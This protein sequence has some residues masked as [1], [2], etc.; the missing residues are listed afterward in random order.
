MSR[1]V[2][3]HRLAAASAALALVLAVGACDQKKTAESEAPAPA[4]TAESAPEPAAAETPAPAEESSAPEAAA[5]ESA[6]PEPAAAEAPAPSETPV[7]EAGHASAEST[8]QA[9][10][11]AT[12]AATV[13]INADDIVLGSPTAPVT[14]IEYASV[15]CSHCAAFHAQTYPQLKAAYIDTGK[16]R[17]VFREFPTSPP[18]LAGAGF[19]LARCAGGS[20]RYMG[21]IG[22]LMAHQKDW[23]FNADPQARFAAFSSIAGQAGIGQE[24]LQTC[25][26]D[27][28]ELDHI[29]A[30]QREGAT[31]FD[32][33]STPTFII[34]GQK[35]PGARSFEAMQEILDPLIAKATE[36]ASKAD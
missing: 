32:V 3:A 30:V 15:T 7:A 1:P 8:A 10:A 27:Q 2:T 18:E 20:E 26:A 17:F 13:A 9:E 35:Y 34:D 14:M 31:L 25:L 4:L 12:E 16:V 5:P 28:A 23:V 19:L 36:A 11:G 6:A 22:A 21:I 29:S 24:K 33:D